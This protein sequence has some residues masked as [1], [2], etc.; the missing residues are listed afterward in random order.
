MGELEVTQQMMLPAAGVVVVD[1][2]TIRRPEEDAWVSFL[3]QLD[4]HND[5]LVR[6]VITASQRRRARQ[7]AT[8]VSWARL[9]AAAVMK[10]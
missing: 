9:L 6:Y 3:S 4:G 8:V 7:K 10:I 1:T 5:L 2:T